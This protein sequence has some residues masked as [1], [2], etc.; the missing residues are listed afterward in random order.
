[1]TKTY[2]LGLATAGVLL[3][4]RLQIGAETTS[5]VER[6]LRDTRRALDELAAV[7][8]GLSH[9]APDALARLLSATEPPAGEPRERD[10]FLVSLRAEVGRLRLAVDQG[11]SPLGDDTVA[12]DG[13]SSTA[14][15]PDDRSAPGV[16]TGLHPSLLQSIRRVDP[17]LAHV[18]TT[19]LQT[20]STRSF[21][22]E[23]YTADAVHQ[24]RLFFR[25]GRYAEA[26]T[27]LEGRVE[28]SLEA[29]YWAARCLERTGHVDEALE[30]LRHVVEQSDDEGLGRRAA[31]DLDFLT[32]KREFERTR[33]ER[34]GR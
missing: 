16:S 17:P 27:L 22:P 8:T 33:L 4:P 5:E 34:S 19:S 26:L 24:A 12:Q 15:A 25:A 20:A 6:A 23:D 3:A 31:R 7:D 1:M 2:F 30:H 29:R 13:A 10:E 14:A 9:D 32:W 18:S 28:H 21:E 11:S